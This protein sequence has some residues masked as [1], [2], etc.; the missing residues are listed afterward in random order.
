[1]KNTII[2]LVGATL[3][4]A[5]ASAFAVPVGYVGGKDDVIDTPYGMSWEATVRWIQPHY[6]PDGRYYTYAYAHISA[7]SQT[8]CQNQLNSYISSG[9]SVV[10]FCHLE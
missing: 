6:G 8:Y 2:S 9:A 10:E 7:S 1:M 3:L 5:T 4:A